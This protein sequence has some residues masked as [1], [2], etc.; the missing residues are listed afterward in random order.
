MKLYRDGS[1]GKFKNYK[2]AITTSISFGLVIG[3]ILWRFMNLYFMTAEFSQTPSGMAFAAII[4]VCACIAVLITYIRPFMS[5]SSGIL[6]YSTGK[7]ST[8]SIDSKEIKQIQVL[9]DDKSV[10]I[11]ITNKMGLT[12]N[13]QTK[14]LESLEPKIKHFIESNLCIPVIGVSEIASQKV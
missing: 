7:V 4:G 8:D 2:K 5:I 11:I 3:F 9:S 13:F 6:Q 10:S 12:I 1:T 14:A